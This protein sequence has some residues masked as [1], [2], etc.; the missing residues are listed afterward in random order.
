V[1]PVDPSSPRS[2]YDQI[3]D[4]IRRQV[5]RG[6]LTPPAQLPNRAQMAKDYG[7]AIETVRRAIDVLAAEGVV[8]I[9][10]T[11][12]T[13]VVRAP[14]APADIPA[15]V[16]DLSGDFA[17]LRGDFADLR[18]QVSGPLLERVGTLEANLMD[19]YGKLGYE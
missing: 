4:D 12:G 3:A 10:S 19:L 11:R 7:V 16:A 9:N 13:W 2:A 17:D 5:E 1:Q 6:E 18:G 14:E 8:R 15:Q